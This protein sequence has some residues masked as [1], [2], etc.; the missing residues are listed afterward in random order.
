MLVSKENIIQLI[1][2]KKPFV[3][4]DILVSSDEQS[5]TTQT[6]ITSDNIFVKNDCFTEP[7]IVE[8]IAQTAAVRAGYFFSQLKDE[9]AEPPVGFIGAIKDLN[10]YQLPKLGDKINT[11]ITVMQQVFDITL[12]KGETVDNRGNKIAD[13]EMKIFVQN[14]GQTVN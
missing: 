13:C 14:S 6:E 8:N 3:M 7:G 1:P 4:I 2:Q 9:N 10:I 11:T 5:T 12:V